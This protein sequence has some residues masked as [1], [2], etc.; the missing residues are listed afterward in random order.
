MLAKA[1]DRLWKKNV[2]KS[3]IAQAQRAEH[4]EKLNTSK[5]ELMIADFDYPEQLV[6]HNSFLERE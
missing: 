1:W 5:L 4:Q 6:G 3:S 2:L